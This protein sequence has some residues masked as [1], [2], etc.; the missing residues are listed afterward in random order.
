MIIKFLVFV[1]GAFVLIGLY[2]AMV[3]KSHADRAELEYWQKRARQEGRE[4]GKA[5]EA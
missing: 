1:G 2:A 4:H 5:E 3:V